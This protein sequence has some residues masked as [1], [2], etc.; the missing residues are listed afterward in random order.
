M[1]K[2]LPA[3]AKARHSQEPSG[4]RKSVLPNG[5][6]I[7]TEKIPYVH[8]VAVG[9]WVDVGSRDEDET[10][11]GISHFIEH[12]A[13]KGTKHYNLRE[14]ARSLESVG[15]YL[16]AFT[17][18]EH[19]CFY[20]RA[21]DTH[22]NRA[23]G[24]LADLVQSPR[25]DRQ[26]MEKEKFVVLE[27]LK[28][29]EDDPDDLIHDYFDK[30]IYHKHPL[31]FPVIGREETIRSF[32]RE[33][34]RDFAAAFYVP[35]NMVIAAAGNLEHEKL[36]DLVRAKF[37][38]GKGRGGARP[39]RRR[40]RVHAPRL[41]TVER[42]IT[43]AHICM[44][45]IACNVRSTHRYPLMMMSTLLGEGMSSRLF[46]SLRE[47]Y[48]LA[49]NVYSFVNTMSD[50]GNFGVYI[51]TDA[52]NIERAL[53]AIRKEFAKLRT[54]KV[55][56]A[57]LRRTA[58]QVKGTIALSLESVSSRMMR[59]GSGEMYY[60]ENFALKDVIDRIDGVTAREI[61]EA[62]KTYLNVDDFSTVIFK[63]GAAPAVP[64]GSSNN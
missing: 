34:I 53:D 30:S 47:R 41:Q 38:R 4:Y 35:G 42:P 55:S 21:L 37:T 50:T 3:P 9:V 19:T 63:P 10:N 54:G 56:D 28:N 36:V 24:V 16:N 51:G 17:T 5:L 26:E 58:S 62:A 61:H 15:G 46:Q 2:S 39:R 22:L 23:I 49:Y 32:T 45:T 48:G 64:P 44:G 14:I 1:K 13:F 40:P 20:A 33:R 60:G 7:V 11:N 18:K 29:A 31:G 12:M 57:E 8:S 52:A 27:E 43:Q 25:F 6:R 59:L